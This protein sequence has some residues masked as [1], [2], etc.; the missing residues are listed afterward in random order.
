[1]K[2]KLLLFLP[3][4]LTIIHSEYL[5][6]QDGSFTLGRTKVTFKTTLQEKPTYESDKLDKLKPGDNLIIYDEIKNNFIKAQISDD[7]G[8]VPLHDIRED[9]KI[10]SFH[11]FI[12]DLASNPF[13][14]LKYTGYVKGKVREDFTT[15]TGESKKLGYFELFGLL[16]FEDAKVKIVR[17]NGE[18]G[19]T[20][21][22]AIVKNEDFEAFKAYQ[23]EI[24]EQR[25]K[26]KEL[27]K[28]R[29]LD[30]LTLIYNTTADYL[31]KNSSPA[32][33]NITKSPDGFSSII[34]SIPANDFAKYLDYNE[35]YYKVRFLDII[36]YVPYSN[37]EESKVVKKEIVTKKMNALNKNEQ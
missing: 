37:L 31:L 36:G 26:E 23:L 15:T 13:D 24:A 14:T 3:A 6:A 12:E 18:V 21:E 32:S 2:L 34:G 22:A 20:D 8:Y 35:G 25:R 11:M 28:K 5:L 1:M 27:K 16:N 4:V 7:I 30:S 19:Y 17:T 10:K 29:H 9:G 33:V